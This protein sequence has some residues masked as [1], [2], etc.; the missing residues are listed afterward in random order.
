MKIS[1]RLVV[2]LSISLF[3][4]SD[5]TNES[6]SKTPSREE[7]VQGPLASGQVV[8][9]LRG[10]GYTYIEVENNGE[11]FWIASSVIN[12]KRNDIVA[13]E[14]GSVMTNFTSFALN[15]KFEEIHFVRTIT[16]LR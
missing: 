3:G 5:F 8:N 7:Q 11:R 6:K 1:I 10:G 9:A 16:I 15:R 4:C 14:N 12:V 13:W 2:I